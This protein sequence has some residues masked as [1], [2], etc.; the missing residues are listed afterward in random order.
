MK[1]PS[2]TKKNPKV[3]YYA[4]GN[5]RQ[6]IISDSENFKLETGYKDKEVTGT[7]D[8]E[9]AYKEYDKFSTNLKTTLIKYQD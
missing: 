2:N 3:K 7:I 4:N 9:S 6:K 1:K 8:S 5:I